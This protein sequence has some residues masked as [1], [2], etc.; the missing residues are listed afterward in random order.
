M[1]FVPLS[2]LD[3]EALPALMRKVVA[4]ALSDARNPRSHKSLMLL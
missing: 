1:R 3:D 2:R 4:H